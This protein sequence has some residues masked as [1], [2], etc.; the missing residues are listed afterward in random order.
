MSG[1]WLTASWSSTEPI[2]ITGSFTPSSTWSTWMGGSTGWTV[3]P[4]H[5]AKS[6][7]TEE[8][9]EIIAGVIGEMIADG[10]AKKNE[11]FWMT[12]APPY[13]TTTTAGSGTPIT[14]TYDVTWDEK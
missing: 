6:E 2:K 5:P 14:V 8:E 4:G 11:F 10:R 3:W 1:D 12:A 13:V 9:Q 7:L